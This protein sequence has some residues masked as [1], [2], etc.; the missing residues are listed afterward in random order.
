MKLLF[1]LFPIILFFVAYKLVDIYVATGV[2]IVASIVQIAWLRVSGKTIEPMQWASLGIIVVF[3]G[4]TLL[5]QD[6]TFIKWKPT[7]LYGLFA[8]VLA[9]GKLFFGR[10][11]IRAVMGKQLSLP[12]PIW[13]R[14]NLAWMF[15]FL[16]MAVLNIVVAYGFSTDTWVNFKLF[17]TL[18]LTL[19]FVLA[20]GFYLGRFIQEEG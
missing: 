2:A 18:A 4:M 16:V 3:G 5:F 17:G 13:Q 15:F 9:G 19:A 1:D 8:G 7:V 10:D 12:D 14:L 6:E 20:Q 11:L